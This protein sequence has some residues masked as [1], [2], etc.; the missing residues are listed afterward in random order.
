VDKCPFGA[1]CSLRPSLLNFFF[2]GKEQKR[3]K[4]EWGEPYGKKAELVFGGDGKG[5]GKRRAVGMNER[6]DVEITRRKARSSHRADFAH[7][8]FSFFVLSLSPWSPL[9]PF[10]YSPDPAECNFAPASL[11]CAFIYFF[12]HS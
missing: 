9:T 10:T 2:L 3:G 7:S 5:V 12:G 6:G 1:F 11:R 8:P 4:G